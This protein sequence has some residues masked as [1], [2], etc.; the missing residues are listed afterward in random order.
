LVLALD[1]PLERGQ[2]ELRRAHEDDAH[3]G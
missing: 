1:Q 3:A 2:R